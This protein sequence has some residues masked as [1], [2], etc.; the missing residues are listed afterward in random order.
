[1]TEKEIQKQPD[2][3]VSNFMMLPE[4]QA[5]VNDLPNYALEDV[6]TFLRK[7][8]WKYYEIIDSEKDNPNAWGKSMEILGRAAA[9]LGRLVEI[10]KKISESTTDNFNLHQEV[11]DILAEIDQLVA[12]K[13][14][15]SC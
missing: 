4:M 3:P 15:T 12:Q 8:I 10:R 5:I 2:E 6:I 7:M 14:N 13:E 9:R 1:M 11:A